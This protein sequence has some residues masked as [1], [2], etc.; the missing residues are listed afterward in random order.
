[1]WEKLTDQVYQVT[2]N[3]LATNVDD[4][5]RAAIAGSNMIAF[6]LCINRHNLQCITGYIFGINL[7][8]DFFFELFAWLD[9]SLC[10]CRKHQH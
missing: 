5:H 9:F 8:C 3:K 10:R 2:L 4:F 6:L 7:G 1:M